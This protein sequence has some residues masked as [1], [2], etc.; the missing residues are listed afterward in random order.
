MYDHVILISL[1][2]L[3]S[4]VLATTPDKE[5][6]EKYGPMRAPDTA[7]ID[8]IAAEGAFFPNCLAAAP[9]TSASHASYFTGRFP[10][11]HGVFEFFNRRLSAPTL[12]TLARRREFRV[13]FK[14]DFP[15]ILGS[16]LGFD[17]DVDDYIVE[18]DGAWLARFRQSSA[19]SI[20]FVHFGGLHIP[21]GFHNLRFGGRD[22]VEKVEAL[23]RELGIDGSVDL[24]DQLVETYRTQ[25][26]LTLLLRYKR[27]V[28]HCYHARA[29]GRLFELYLEGAEY[30]FR[31]RFTAFWKELT[32]ALQGTRS[33]VV[34]FGDH[35]EEYDE[36]SYGHFNTVAEG[37]L[38]VPLI[39]WGDGI[40]RGRHLSRVRAVDL[41]PTLLELLGWP[42]EVGGALDGI[43]LAS[44]I[45]SNAASREQ[46]SFAQAYVA[47]AD[48]F[49]R[50]QRRAMDLGQVE[51]E[52]PH[53][54]HREVV[55]DGGLK[56][57]RKN[58]D[59]TL[60]DVFRAIAPR[61]QLWRRSGARWMVFHNEEAEMA[62]E[63]RLDDYNAKRIAA[64]S[65]G[66][67]SDD[68]RRQ[69]Q[70]MGYRV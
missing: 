20:D 37:V 14:V 38:R 62:L 10:L 36:E 45:L 8:Q 16:F 42:Q 1:D 22:Y 59:W 70:N 55:Y 69:L 67:V 31:R 65:I 68:V 15:V 23:E 60:G 61:R 21:Y 7:I 57:V 66:A 64:P 34:I 29:F 52:L 44:V 5:W 56:L 13:R 35:G 19:R 32:A 2:T 54:L 48:E 3:R 33:L 50:F 30:F 4:D 58:F 12:F 24:T 17:Q 43:S 26:D 63:R 39:F 6:P 47:N 41:L 27:I 25:D 40:P 49:V 51:G 46:P 28:Q 53:V 9:Y 11:R 18:D